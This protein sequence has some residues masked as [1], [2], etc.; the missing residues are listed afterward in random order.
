MKFSVTDLLTPQYVALDRDGTVI[1][2]VPYLK[3]PE[4]VELTSS[5]GFAI[6]RLNRVGTRVVLVT[7]QSV[8]ARGAL[9]LESLGEIHEKVSGLLAEQDAHLD[10]I[11]IC[12]HAPEDHCPCRKPKPW[13]LARYLEQENVNPRDGY[14]VGDNV[15][16]MELAFKIGAKPVHVQGGVHCT[17]EVAARYAGVPSAT[18]LGSAVDFILGESE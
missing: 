16:D 6:A 3:R 9:T 13:L 18:D 14:V 1:Q 7:N 17:L 2:Y 10:A 12:P 5:A 11:L 4:D 15:T 8:V